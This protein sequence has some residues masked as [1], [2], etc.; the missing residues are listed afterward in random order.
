VAADGG[1]PQ[2]GAGTAAGAGA[3][4]DGGKYGAGFD[5]SSREIILLRNPVQ[6]C[7]LNFTHSYG[8]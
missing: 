4:A 6:F 8:F 2:G 7:V 1:R 5:E 3:E